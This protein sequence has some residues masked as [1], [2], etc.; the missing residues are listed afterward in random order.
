[1]CVLTMLYVCVIILIYMCVL[2]LLYVCPRTAICVS[3]YCYMC[4][5][6]LLYVSSYCYMCPHTAIYVSSYHYICVLILSYYYMCPHTAIY[7]SH[8]TIYVSSSCCARVL[9]SGK[10]SYTSSLRPRPFA[11]SSLHARTAT[12]SPFSGTSTHIQQHEYTHIAV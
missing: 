5:L 11:R 8:T 7:V 1:M 12:H 10:A 9:F 2:I 4:V 3:S 6:I